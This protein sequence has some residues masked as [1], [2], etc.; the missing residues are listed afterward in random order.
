MTDLLTTFLAVLTLTV[1]VYGLI[2]KILPRFTQVREMVEDAMEDGLTLDEVREIAEE[3]AEVAEEVLDTV[4]EAKEEAEAVITKTPEELSKML[5]K[6]L[7]A[8]ADEHGL[9]T[10]G[11]KAELVERLAEHMMA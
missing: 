9:D 7:Q 5:K 3:V 8:L 6:D 2:A 4:E 10:T 1:I 11:L